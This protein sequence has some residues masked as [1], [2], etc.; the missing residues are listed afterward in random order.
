MIVPILMYH[1]IS[2]STNNLSVSIYNFEKQM[3]FMKRNNYKTI[4]FKNL[5]NLDKKFKYF[6]ITFDDGYEDVYDNALPIMKKFG[7]HSI[8]YF[9]TNLIGKHNVWDQ[10][11]ENFNE[12][13]LM[14]IDKIRSWLNNGMDIGAHSATHQNLTSLNSIKK[15][16]EIETPKK[17]FKDIFSID[18]DSFS[19][20]FGK[21]DDEC[22]NIVK[23]NFNYAVTTQRS[24]FK[25]NKFSRYLLPRIPINK[26]TSMFKFFL[27]INTFYEDIKFN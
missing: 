15:K 22:L 7:F 5:D 26:S 19:Y 27:K 8:C 12:L 3:A 18:T 10:N 2:S 13:K 20:P 9:V 14:N 6:I 1:S 11:L 24:R 16:F 4:S 23:K 17:Y 25:I 21:F